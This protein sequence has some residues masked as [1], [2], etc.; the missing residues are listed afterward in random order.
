MT[1]RPTIFSAEMVRAILEG[2]KTQDRRVIRYRGNPPEFCG[3]EGCQADPCCWGWEDSEYGDWITIAPD[4]DSRLSYLE[5]N[6]TIQTGDRLWVREAWSGEYWLY[7]VKPS[8]RFGVVNPDRLASLVPETWYWADGSPSYGDWERPRPSIHMPRWASRITLIVKDVRVERVQ[9]I[10]ESDAAVE[11]ATATTCANVV[12]PQD[13][14]PSHRSGF[15]ILWN[16][17]HAKRPENQWKANPWVVAITF[18]TIRENIDR[19]E[20][21]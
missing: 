9:D 10:S 16:K 21:I 3:P 15:G 14:F 2:R 4:Q 5:L 17:I 8:H 12:L 13:G 7:G 19:L 18:E 11:G 1:D 6:A 20:T